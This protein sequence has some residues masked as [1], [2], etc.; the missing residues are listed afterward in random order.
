MQLPEALEEALG[1]V[2]VA[3]FAEHGTISG[4]LVED[5]ST[6]LPYSTN[7]L[8]KK[9]QILRFKKVVSDA[10]MTFEIACD[11]LRK[12]VDEEMAT[13]IKNPVLK[14]KAPG[15]AA[16]PAENEDGEK[17]PDV[18]YDFKWSE[19][20]KKQVYMCIMRR[21]DWVKASNDLAEQEHK[22]KS[23]KTRG[24]PPKP[25]TPESQKKIIY[26]KLVQYWPAGWM[27]TG[28]IANIFKQF[29]ARVRNAEKTKANAA[30]AATPGAPR[31]E[32]PAKQVKRKAPAEASPARA[33][34]PKTTKVVSA[35]AVATAAITSAPAAVPTPPTQF[36]TVIGLPAK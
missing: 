27:S 31:T 22:A 26:K 1:R 30:A 7:L 32:S 19:P 12:M 23:A 33:T 14:E 6:F 11:N 35:A 18:E 9:M 17:Q 20:M 16:A 4:A 34:K 24:D 13:Q 21:D 5:V 2:A 29:R 10:D 3:G 25:I 28:R 8:K 36:P 15:A